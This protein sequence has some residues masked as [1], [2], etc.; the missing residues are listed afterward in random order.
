[1]LPD[2]LAIT[3]LRQPVQAKLGL[4]GSK[5]VT[6]R[7][8]TLAALADGEVVIRG[9]LWSDDVVVMVDALRALGIEVDVSVDPTEPENRRITVRGSSGVV[10]PGGTPEAPLSLF[11]GLAGTTARFLTAMLCLGSGVYR[12]HGTHAMHQRPQSSLFGA[13][14]SL[15]YRLDSEND[16][17]PVTI[18]GAGPRVG[19]CE[20]SIRESSQ[21]ASALLLSASLGG[22]QVDV[23]D[24]DTES[25]TYVDMTRALIRT[26]PH[27][28]G[29]QHVE[30]DAS[31][32]SYFQAAKFLLPESQIEILN[33]PTTDWQIDTAFVK[34]LPLGATISRK[35]DLGDSIMTAIVI[36]SLGSRKVCFTDLGRLRYQECERVQALRAELT[37]CGAEVREH[38]DTLEITPT[39]LRGAEIETYGDHRV[40]MCFATLGLVVPG[41]RLRDPG[42]VRKT[43]PG[44]FVKLAAAPPLGLG[45]TITNASGERMSVESLHA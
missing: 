35:T 25:S 40:A 12:L 16:R 15:G 4:P 42:C 39:A 21:F 8:L 27:R 1:M 17:L 5:S 36:A 30:A 24:E 29:E 23:T 6:N 13:L 7:A 11:V 20:V 19:R 45:V 26:F 9:A 37:K 10:P 31:G 28:G 38:E 2:L 44:F 18:Y 34:H 22:W 33:W 14:R 3:P 43:F 32:G 41:I